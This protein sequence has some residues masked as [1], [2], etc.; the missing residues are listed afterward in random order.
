MREM[1]F[2]NYIYIEREI[3]SG[4]EIREERVKKGI[5][6]IGGNNE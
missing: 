2:L 4:S 6:G 5:W 3:V 1:V